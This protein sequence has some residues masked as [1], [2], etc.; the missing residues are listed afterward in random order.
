MDP[1]KSFRNR[2]VG[3][4]LYL[5]VQTKK[6]PKEQIKY[7]KQLF[8]VIDGPIGITGVIWMVQIGV[9]E[10]IQ[11]FLAMH[12]LLHKAFVRFYYFI[13]VSKNNK[14]YPYFID[15]HLILHQ[16]KE[17]GKKCIPGLF[18]IE[19]MTLFLLIVV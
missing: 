16:H 10:Y 3:G 15:F 12:F 1:Q 8:L 5:H 7:S 13:I 17:M 6:S 11:L 14:I 4:D 19:N 9:N 18:C 2:L